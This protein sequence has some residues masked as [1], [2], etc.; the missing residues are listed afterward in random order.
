MGSSKAKD[1]AGELLSPA[2]TVNADI[3]EKPKPE[4]EAASKASGGS[5][6]RIFTYA[7]PIDIALEAIAFVAAAGSGVGLAIVNLVL[8]EFI[9]ILNRFVA[10][11]STP[12]E[13]MSDV[14]KYCLYFVYIGIGRLVLVY[15][16]TTL[17]TYVAYRI[18][19]NIRQQFFK[20]ALAQEIAF[21]DLGS[22]GSISMQATT[23]GNLIHSGIAEK[24]GLCVQALATFIAA[25]VVAFTSQ[26]KLT[27]ILIWLA[28]ALIV[29]MGLVATA[30]AKLET[31][32]L[33][34]YAQGGAFAE[35]ILSTPRTVH[36][37][38]ARSRLVARYDTYLRRAKALGDKK[39]PVFGL[40][41]SVEYF[42]I[43]AG[44]GLAFWQGIKM[45]ANQEVPSLGTVFTVLMSVII[46][47]ISITMIAP[48]TISFGRAATAAGQVFTLI[49]RVSQIDPFDQSGEKPA[50]T[51]GVLDVE[52]VTFSYP[53]R[54][55]VTILDNFSLHIPAGKVTALVGASGSGK[56]TIVG[57]IERWYQPA[58]GTIKL[59][60]IP[61]EKMNL[62]WLR[63]KI[64]LV[65][66]EPVLFNGSVFDNIA[67]GLVGTPWQHE[68]R[69]KQM[70][71]V[72]QAA[73]FAFAHDFISALPEG[74][75]TRIG[76]RGG[77]LSGG[78]KQRV[79]IARSIVS[80]PKVLL[81]DE[82]TS[83]LDPQAE[84]IVQ[85][86]LDNV[87]RSRTT[88]VIAHKLA[89]IRRADNIVVMADGRILEQ[90]THDGLLA[91]GGAYSRLVAAQNIAS[92]A[93]SEASETDSASED[94]PKDQG[95]QISV[96]K[97]LTRRATADQ[98][99]LDGLKDR[100]NYDKAR[101]KGLLMSVFGLM[102]RTPELRLQYMIILVA[103]MVASAVFPGQ[104]L[105]LAKV[106]DVFQLDA[107]EM[108]RQGNFYALMFLVLSLGCLLCYFVMGWTT[109]IMAQTMNKKFRESMLDSMLRQDIQFFDRPENTTGALTSRLDSYPQAILELMSFN[110]AL[111]LINILNILGSSILA[112]VTQWKLGLVGVFAGLPPM[113]LAGYA[114]IR[115]ETGMEAKNA[116]RF[117]NSASIA[118]ESITAIRTVS[119]LAVEST[120]LQRYSDEL[121]SAVRQS[122][123]PL[124]HMMFWFAF[125]QAIEYF[126]LALGF[127][128]GCRLVS[129]GEITFYQFFV[130]FMGTFFAG[131]AASQMFGYTSSITKGKSAANYLFWIEALQPL[132]RADTPENA[133]HGPAD[134][135][136]RIELDGVQF[137]YPLRPETRV[138]RGVDL[139]IKRGE[140]VAFV[141]ASGCG[142]STMI[143][144]LER[145]YDPTTGCIRVDGERLAEINPRL[146][147]RH[148]S[149]VQQEPTLYQGSV[150]DNVLLGRE[151]AASG[152]DDVDAEVEKALRAANA[153]DFA[154]SL[155]DGAG[156]ECGTSGSQ[157]SGGQRQRIAIAR[158][159]IR[160]PGVLLLD[161]ATSALDTASEKLVQAA[162]ADAA[163]SGERITIAV[164]HR[165]STIKDADR[166]C[167][168]F[169]GR[170]VE[171]GTHDEL[172]ALGRMY[173]D[174]CAA[175]SLDKEAV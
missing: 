38:G 127:W 58:N 122:V 175:Q 174:M 75:D 1:A 28:P 172:L 15:I 123:L 25:F 148:V 56:S 108:Q 124:L 46:A 129:S 173:K 116:H 98:Q 14:S 134:G 4:D 48:Y 147:R 44:M 96:Q 90:G 70:E 84:G 135:A 115:L 150:R 153:W 69:E 39:S 118:S 40:L 42:L 97:T 114:R 126:I 166:I 163:A 47:T 51:E 92:N 86:A 130:S 34:I 17:T 49:D 71:K 79:A 11:Q 158:S 139:D 31:K 170:I 157:L 18:V 138:L 5:Y 154:M 168:F 167:V 162:L 91:A 68:P 161:E 67:Y 82:A 89:T 111:V 131:Q 26:W 156:T 141:G 169:G 103:C 133:D 152:D 81:L 16:Y 106:L 101:H 12:S 9:T 65:Q 149:L 120:M 37:L 33:D 85:K 36:S 132:I 95:D 45:V 74:Y 8:G 159:L 6:F 94:E 105:I 125:T 72:A 119:S 93:K 59:D 77:L 76:E 109:N 43:Y 145:F 83:A 35:S 137:S 117:A 110:I 112:L 146:Y 30:E 155:P 27:L 55:G 142:K 99:R 160:R 121:G 63:T 61:I 57:L 73:A 52:N 64:R 2:D 21:F 62:N 23:N 87:S 136:G 60:G 78:Q 140:F 102:R 107:D 53:T 165:L 164:A 13:F 66:Q 41:F 128:Y 88:I 54:P 29:L 22:G 24:L 50:T 7:Q 171:S 151:D 100:D 104:A 144:M 32:M 20:A 113:L 80:D 10:G 19:R 143:A 3:S